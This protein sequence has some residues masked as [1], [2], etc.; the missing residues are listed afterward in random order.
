MAWPKGVPRGPRQ[1][2]SEVTPENTIMTEPSTETI[3]PSRAALRP[4][5]REEDSRARA[6]ARSA[7]LREHL[8]NLDQGT[9]KY[10]IDQSIIPDGWSYEWKTLTVYGA[11]NPS[12]QV[13]LRK[14]G[15]EPV[16]A[17]RHPELM[18]TG[19]KGATIIV[20]GQQLMER[21]AD[22]TKEM[23]NIDA[24]RARRQVR[25]KEEQL[26]AAPQG[27]FER[28]NKDQPLVKIRK[29]FEPMSIPE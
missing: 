15:W 27:Q 7:E 18:P 14:T 10:A 29:T 9:D 28:S 13:A 21:P 4:P 6:A 25:A 2:K 12:Y 24:Q 1:V 8:G 5:V 3:A 22:I 11:E 26:V 19:Y 17:S 23:R 20:D 16:P